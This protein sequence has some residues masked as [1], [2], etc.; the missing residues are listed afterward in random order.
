MQE[1]V[2]GISHHIFIVPGFYGYDKNGIVKTIGTSG[3]D[4]TAGMLAK[5]IGYEIGT[6]PGNTSRYEH[7]LQIVA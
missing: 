3:S 4:I 1:H 5:A 7:V 2:Y 6:K